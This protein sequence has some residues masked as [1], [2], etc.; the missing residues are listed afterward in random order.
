MPRF[1]LVGFLLLV[2]SATAADDVRFAKPKDLNGYFP[3]TPPTTV[4]EWDARKAELRTRLL[5][6]NGLYPMPPKTELQPVI[7][8]L[9]A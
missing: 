1:A 2:G 3:F 7:L 5:V 6:A 4:A 8:G 9:R